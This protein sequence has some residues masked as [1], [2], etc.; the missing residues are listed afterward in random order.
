MAHFLPKSTTQYNKIRRAQENLCEA[1]TWRGRLGYFPGRTGPSSGE[2][3]ND[4]G[5]TDP[6]IT[7]PVSPRLFARQSSPPA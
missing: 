3:T 7:L 2:N 5:E 6:G 4:G 1:Q